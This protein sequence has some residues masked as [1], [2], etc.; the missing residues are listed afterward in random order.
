MIAASGQCHHVGGPKRHRGLAGGVV[1][2]GKHWAYRDF[3]YRLGDRA[4]SVARDEAVGST[5]CVPRRGQA[6]RLRGR[7]ANCRIVH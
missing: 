6:E 1:P 2:P 4:V 5:I 7:A 3:R